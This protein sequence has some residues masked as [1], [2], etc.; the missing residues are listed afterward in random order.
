[1]KLNEELI[2]TIT[3]D[4]VKHE[5]IVLEVYLDTEGLHTCG[6]G[7]L[8]KLGDEEFKKPVG[9]KITE[10][11][12]LELFKQDLA[13]S[14]KEC[15]QLF[16]S[17]GDYPDPVQRVLVNMTFNLGR[18]RLSKFK[19]MIKAVEA[20]DWNEAAN[21][22]IDSRWYRQVKSRGV[23]LVELMRSVHG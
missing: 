5:G 21:Q 15:E 12:A 2:G 19:N 6:V 8:I 23:E 10:E 20:N 1:M 11:R 14:I 16:P 7:H 9:T 3:E 17:L 18:P 22:M 4:L 13:V